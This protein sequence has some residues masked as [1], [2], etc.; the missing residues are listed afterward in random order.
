MAQGKDWQN[1]M[2]PEEFADLLN[3]WGADLET[4]PLVERDAA[5][6]L[7]EGSD[8]AQAMLAEAEALTDVLR[9]VPPVPASPELKARVLSDA[10]GGSVAANGDLLKALWPFGPIWRPALGLAAAACLGI[11]LGIASPPGTAVEEQV[12]E[13]FGEDVLVIAGNLPADVGQENDF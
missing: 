1:G 4:W 11:A 13:G 7:I 6:R 8:R 3:R 10:A 9:E 2:S 5:E 12:V